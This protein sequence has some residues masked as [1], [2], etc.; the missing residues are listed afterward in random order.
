LYQNGTIK[1][2]IN[3][4]TYDK[5]LNPGYGWSAF[6]ATVANFSAVANG[7]YQLVPVYKNE[8]GEMVPIL[9][10]NNTISKYDVTITD[11]YIKF[12]SQSNKSVLEL[13]SSPVTLSNIYKN[14]IGQFE[15]K[16]KNTSQVE[17]YAQIG[18]KLV[19]ADNSLSKEIINSLV[20]IG[21]GETKTIQ[22]ADSVNL[23]PGSYKLYVTYDAAN[24]N[25]VTTFPTTVMG[26]SNFV[27]TVD[28]LETPTD[29]PSL[30]II[31]NSVNMP[32]TV[33]IGHD[34]TMTA[35]IANSGGIFQNNVV[36]FIFAMTPGSSVGYFG[37]QSIIID[38]NDSKL[39]TFTGN[40]LDLTEGNYRTAIYSW[41]QTINNWKQLSSV[42][43]F[44]LAI[45]TG[46]N[47]LTGSNKLQILSN[48]VHDILRVSL[49][50]AAKNLSVYDLNGK[51]TKSIT[52]NNESSVEIP[53]SD[54]QKGIYIIRV[55]TTEGVITGKMIKN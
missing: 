6:P 8:N 13:V 33:Y 35:S 37:Y 48:P 46:V 25:D 1:N 2:I 15:V 49:P 31:P 50:D 12:K 9:T 3:Q 36:A 40:V 34:F 16:I 39:V 41:D 26:P 18:I 52:L 17:Y 28:V 30:T 38:K 27:S 7:V 43:Y 4:Y 11:V 22:L 19:S 42:S 47:D 5:S 21:V 24:Q 51:I 29:A 20:N 55:Q 44:T 54:L 14:K 45:P 10:G 53:V 23:V 32:A